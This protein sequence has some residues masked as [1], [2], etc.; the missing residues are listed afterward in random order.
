MPFLPL[1]SSKMLVFIIAS[2]RVQLWGRG[3]NIFCLLPLSFLDWPYYHLNSLHAFTRFAVSSLHINSWI[4]HFNPCLSTT[5]FFWLLDHWYGRSS[6]IIALYWRS[7][8]GMFCRNLYFL[9]QAQSR[10][11]E[12]SRKLVAT[13]ILNK[14]CLQSTS[15]L[16]KLSSS[17]SSYFTLLHLLQ[18]TR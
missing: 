12:I 10:W 16:F 3:Y 11:L 14:E 6:F 17:L 4:R 8:L 13:L 1:L 15:T 18:L 9:V 7:G 2:H 5:S